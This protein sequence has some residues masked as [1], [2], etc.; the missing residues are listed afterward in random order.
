MGLS[1]KFKEKL[2]SA[3]GRKVKEK[4]VE[5]V[6]IP[7][8]PKAVARFP[9]IKWPWSKKKETL[10]TDFSKPVQLPK[11][12]QECHEKL[13]EL[14]EKRQHHAE[15]R[16]VY[17]NANKN[18]LAMKEQIAEQEIIKQQDKWKREL[19]IQEKKSK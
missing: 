18:K 7:E 12:V 15:Q 13:A 5:E 4:I 19:I 9:K 17:R 3:F 1:K 8:R 10:D 6:V 16:S 14:Q 11:K 2:K